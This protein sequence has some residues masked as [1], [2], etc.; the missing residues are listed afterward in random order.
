MERQFDSEMR[1]PFRQSDRLIQIVREMIIEFEK[2]YHVCLGA[3]EVAVSGRHIRGETFSEGNE[4]SIPASHEFLHRLQ[5]WKDGVQWWD[6]TSGHAIHGCRAALAEI[7]KVVER[8]PLKTQSLVFS[9]LAS[10]YAVTRPHERVA[11]DA[12][13]L[14][15]DIGAGTTDY[16]L[17]RDANVVESGVIAAG[18]DLITSEIASKLKISWRQAEEEKVTHGTVS[19]QREII[20]E[21]IIRILTSVAERAS[22]RRGKFSTVYVTGGTSRIRNIERMAA[23]V[24]D[25]PAYV[26]LAANLS[27]STEPRPEYSTVLGL[28]KYGHNRGVC[29]TKRSDRDRIESLRRINS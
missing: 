29:C 6:F 10:A 13:I 5:S 8:L 1:V 28:L 3:V 27:R 17:F 9:G 21:Q 14:T 19:P 15:V 2:R 4:V 18:G 26:V 7:V 22:V 23:A 25:G 12:D 11:V 16:L 24:F 20:W